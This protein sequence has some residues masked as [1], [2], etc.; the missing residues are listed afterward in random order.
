MNKYQDLEQNIF[1]I[2]GSAS[3]QAEN[4]KTFPSNF[5]ALNVGSEYIRVSIIPSG[6]GININSVSGILIIDI[7]TSAGSGPKAATRIADKLDLY[8]SGKKIVNTQFFASGLSYLGLDIDNRALYRSS[9][10]IPFKH[11]GVF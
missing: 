3:W 1:S 6:E 11:F 10:S 8:L 9:Y 4:I 5:I 2:F 7:F